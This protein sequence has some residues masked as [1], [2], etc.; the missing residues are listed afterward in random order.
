MGVLLQ[1]ANEIRG[2]IDIRGEQV[3]AAKLKKVGDAAEKAGDSL[4]E[5]GGQATDAAKATEKS[6]DKVKTTA[7]DFGFLNK[8]V[9]ELSDSYRGMIAEFNRTGDTSL[10]KDIG[11]EK[12]QLRK[13]EGL[14]KDLLPAP[15]EVAKEG[16]S[17][18]SSLVSAVGA[19]AKAGGPY[20]TGVLV[21]AAAAATPGIAAT[22]GAA[23]VGGVGVGGIVGGVALAAKD[24]RVQAVGKEVGETLTSEFQDATRGFVEPVIRSLQ[25]VGNAGWADR[26]APTFDKLADKVDP[27]TDGLL[28][29]VDQALPGLEH[30]ADSAGPVLDVLADGL[31]QLGA[32]IGD[33]F[34]SISDDPETLADALELFIN[35]ASDA[36]RISGDLIETL[37]GIYSAAYDVAEA[38][39]LISE[40]ELFLQK[41]TKETSG[42]IK[43]LVEHTDA[44][45]QKMRD[46]EAA[47]QDVFGRTLSVREA[48]LEYE[49]SIDDL[50]EELTNGKRTLD[51]HTQAGRDN[52][53]A[54]NDVAKAI[55]GQREAN[56]ANG[57]SMDAANAKYDRQLEDLRK[58]LLGLGYNKDA[59]NKY[60]AEL[61]NVPTQA[62]TEIHLRGIKAALADVK[63]LAG[64]LGAIGGYG[65]QAAISGPGKRASG[66]PVSSGQSYIVGEN[67]PEL[68]Q[69]GGT[70]GYVHNAG[71][72]QGMLSGQSGGASGPQVV[73]LN[74]ALVDPVTGQ[75]MRR[76]LI[77]D[78]LARGVPESTVRSAYP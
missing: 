24:P 22:L 13:F 33:F 48:T 71:Q 64:A 10:L 65:V 41:S 62:L 31:P 1:M 16:A 50:T 52:W 58:T 54:I 60:I 38:L 72:T 5:L 37:I 67:G 43:N 19:G 29:L 9:I 76:A 6:G 7:D 8:R 11:K 75:V 3:A 17:L 61:K 15:A 21:A 42:E 66:G 47:I 51:E 63:E 36:I 55:E 69:M 25:K 73:N 23:I 59:V 14:A 56:V 30:A 45:E 28:G 4:E 20:L 2:N 53:S 34:H 40:E 32:A 57:M 77:D 39:G 78:A 44:A 70:G 18:G 74:V 26:L 27:L 46:F 49:Q 35:A 12:R 68:L